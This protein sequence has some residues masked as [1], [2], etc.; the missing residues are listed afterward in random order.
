MQSSLLSPRFSRAAL[1][2]GTGIAVTAGVVYVGGWILSLALGAADGPSYRNEDQAALARPASVRV[3]A[4]A[5]GSASDA[6]VAVAVEPVTRA[7]AAAAAETLAA[8]SVDDPM[9]LACGSQVRGAGGRAGGREGDGGG[10]REAR[11]PRLTH[12]GSRRRRAAARALAGGTTHRRASLRRYSA[13]L[14]PACRI[15]PRLIAAS[16]SAGCTRRCCAPSCRPRRAASRC[17]RRAPRPSPC[18]FRRV[19]APRPPA[20]APASLRLASPPSRPS[21]SSPATRPP[22]HPHPLTRQ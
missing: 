9:M 22:A 11:R 8:G 3:R 12:C 10:F 15:S 18:G 16:R 20:A 21:S 5:G 17:R 7:S 14:H 1:V 13:R 6:S 19:R 2:V 4:G